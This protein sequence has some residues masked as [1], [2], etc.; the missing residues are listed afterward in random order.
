MQ[1]AQVHVADTNR[2]ADSSFDSSS[3]YFAFIHGIQIT[4]QIKQNS[5]KKT[6][7]HYIY[8]ITVVL[9]K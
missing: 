5:N 9:K 7:A 3:I 1:G 4:V 6:I 2:Y 8:N